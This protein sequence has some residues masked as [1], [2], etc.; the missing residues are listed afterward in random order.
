MKFID[1]IKPTWKKI[2]ITLTL[3]I[4]FS[5]VIYILLGPFPWAVIEDQAMHPA[6]NIGSIVFIKE[7][8]F[9]NLNTGDIAVYEANLNNPLIM[10]VISINQ[11]SKTF[12]TKGDNNP[13]QLSFE[14]NI[15]ENQLIG[16]VMF[17][18][19]YLGYF[20]IY[21][22]GGL[23]RLVIIYLFACIIN[24]GFMKSKSKNKK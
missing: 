21:H 19:P 24:L 23:F 12:Q 2:G 1:F 6:I 7:T 16:K 10:R 3:I 4:L 17:S 15:Q 18:V 20:D 5:I 13:K 11:E 22:I 14:N 8:D 9:N